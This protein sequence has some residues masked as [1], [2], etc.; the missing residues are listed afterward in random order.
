M[1]AGTLCGR[2]ALGMQLFETRLQAPA[3]EGL[4]L[5][6]TCSTRDSTAG[7]SL[8]LTLEPLGADG[9]IV[10][11][12]HIFTPDSGVPICTLCIVMKCAPREAEHVT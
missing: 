6:Y 7:I 1:S 5:Q 12:Q 9:G 4:L 3:E 2:S 10:S 8:T 11:K